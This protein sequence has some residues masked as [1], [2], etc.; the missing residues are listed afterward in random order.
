M[1]PLFDNVPSRR[2]PLVN[3]TLIGLNVLV[4]LWEVGQGP[5]LDEV[6]RA[7]GVVPA[8]FVASSGLERWVPVFTSMF[9]HG[10]VWHLVS[11]ML[12]LWIFGDNVE[13]RMGHFRYLLFYLLCGVAASLVHIYTDP[14]STI[15]SVGASGAISG[16]LAAYLVLYPMAYVYTLIPLF[17]WVEIVAIPALLYLGLWFL[18]QLVNGLFALSATSLQSGGGIAWWAHIGGFMAGLILV[19][20]FRRREERRSYPDE[21]WPY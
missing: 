10:G 19:W 20:I 17:F 5:R 14:T 6:F 18:S 8:V 9:L 16:V 13:D 2:P 3:Y 1:I 15:P 4:F 12:A 21:H 11:N 7:Y